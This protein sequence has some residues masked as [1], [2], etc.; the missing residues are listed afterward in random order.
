MTK[1]TA[2]EEFWR[3]FIQREGDLFKF[4]PECE[5]ERERIFDQL[6][7][8]LQRVHRDLTFEFAPREARREFVVSA[9]GIRSAFPAAISL[10]DAAPALARWRVTAFR[11]RRTSVGIVEIAG[12][13]VDPS[14]VQF[15]L[16][17]N[18]KIAGIYLFIPGFREEDVDWK[19]I[20][21]WMLDESL[22]EYD[23]E[24]RLGLI[25]MLSPHRR[26]EGDRYPLAKL[27]ALF[28]KLV[29]RLEGRSEKPS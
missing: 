23:V 11:P 2:Q 20:G 24:S 1:T 4:D 29:S 5:T 28:D 10:V 27:P 21:Y 7:T 26:T 18:G 6:A 14:D 16:L 22:G 17:D 15:S 8:A 9:G 13:R 19:Q 3:W 12:K 25:E